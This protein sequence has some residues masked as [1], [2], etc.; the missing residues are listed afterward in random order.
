[1]A[2]HTT[3]R[4]YC[5]KD[6]HVS[7]SYPTQN[8]HSAD[9]TNMGVAG[10]QQNTALLAFDTNHGI[11][12]GARIL[13]AKLYFAIKYASDTG[14]YTYT[15]RPC[16]GSWTETGVTW[17]TI[18]TTGDVS[19]TA[20]ISNS[21]RAVDITNTFR[22]W[23]AG[24]YAMA[25]GLYITCATANSRKQIY[26]H[27]YSNADY[28][29]YLVIEWEDPIS[30]PVPDKSV[31][32]LGET[33]NLSMQGA[34]SDRTHNITYKIGGTTV[35]TAT[36]VGASDAY[37]LPLDLASNIPDAIS[38]S[39]TILCETFISGVS[40]GTSSVHVT[41][42][43][44]NNIVP[45]IAS[46]LLS[47]TVSNWPSALA[48]KWIQNVSR[49]RVQVSASGAY[50]SSIRSC[51][52]V[53]CGI[54]YK[55]M[56]VTAYA[57]SSSGT[58]TISVTVTD[59]RGRTATYNSSITVVAYTKPKISY[60]VVNRC[61][62]SGIYN[63][64]GVYAMVSAQGNCSAL[65]GLNTL[66]AVVSYKADGDSNWTNTNA[67]STN[68]F[69]LNVSSVVLSA[70]GVF[71]ALTKYSMRLTLTDL[72]GSVVADSVLPTRI[73][74]LHA[75]SNGTGLAM[76]IGT[77]AGD[78]DGV[79]TFGLAINLVEDIRAQSMQNLTFLGVNPDFEDT[80]VNWGAKGPCY[81]WYNKSGVSSVNNPPSLYGFLINIPYGPSGNYGEVR[82]IWASQR[83]GALYHRGGNAD[84]RTEWK[85]II[86]SAGGTI[87]GALTASTLTSNGS[88]TGYGDL[89]LNVSGSSALTAVLTKEKYIVLRTRDAD[90]NHRNLYLH[91]PKN[92][93]NTRYALTLDESIDGVW[94]SYYV[95][96][97]TNWIE[98]TPADGVTTPG[99]YGNGVLRYRAE[100]K[101]VY[102][103]GSIN[104]AWDGSGNKLIATLPEGYRP[105]GGYSYFFVPTSGANLSR[106]FVKT[107]GAI[108]LE[109]KRTLGGS[110]NTDSGWFDLNMDF[111][112]D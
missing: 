58:N 22:S 66:S 78:S 101:H 104:T 44:P 25:N 13:S 7:K 87:D 111:W 32:V 46:V 51:A 97:Q 16:G 68:D 39:M 77:E 48:G 33:L 112:T 71:D 75:K 36:G 1:M 42:S 55:G 92:V 2:Q 81:A 73:V 37:A 14:T 40:Q 82:Q 38:G 59:S 62:S 98:L 110:S 9:Y 43:V 91:N 95:P 8:F 80:T 34:G 3:A 94:T 35:R 88:I 74:A 76:G 90:G 70:G 108:Y 26:P 4:L 83:D 47:E 5:T 18:P 21:T 31:Y 49:P 84:G 89:I 93:A 64:A 23:F 85:Q 107:D 69:T 6:T 24:T 57:P 56:D 72:L 106:F 27:D 67:L 10:G 79:V 54:N 15:V 17:N 96:A 60:F 53:F 29:P 50:G 12:A 45:T 19:D 103:A 105:T 63:N 109:W 86:D 100:G 28:R 11:A 20:S 61:D 52:I 102:V 65:D 99:T 30:V 41:L